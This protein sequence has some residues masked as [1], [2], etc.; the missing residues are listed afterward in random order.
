MSRVPYVVSFVLTEHLIF[1][2]MQPVLH[3]TNDHTYRIFKLKCKEH[4]CKSKQAYTSY[5]YVISCNEHPVL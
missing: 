1:N 4:A 5:R 2:Y 3:G